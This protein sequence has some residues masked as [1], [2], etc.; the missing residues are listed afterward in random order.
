M[1]LIRFLAFPFSILYAIIT[2]FRNF[3]FDVGIFKSTTFQKPIIAVGNLSVGGTGKTPQIEYLINLLNNTYKIAVLSRGY[4]RKTNGFYVADSSSS[5][6]DIGDEPLQFFR[7]FEDVI[8]AVDENR[9]HGIQQLEQLENKP[10][11]ILLDDA[12]QHRKVK[13]GFYVM[14]TKYDDLFSND[15]VLPTGNLRE[16]R[17]GAKRADVIV[18]TKSPKNIDEI[19][20]NEIKKL[21]SRYFKGAI[22]FSTIKYSENLKSNTTIEIATSTL[23]IYNVLLVTGIAN[24]A[25]IT[26]YLTELNCSFSHLKYVDHHSFSNKE[27]KD[28]QRQFSELKSDTKIILT[29]EKDFVRLSHKIENLYYLPIENQFIN[30]KNEFDELI[31]SYVKK[32]L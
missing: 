3:L 29:T 11:V 21:I 19:E 32:A 8:V 22:F 9:V 15:F 2:S 30:T 14:L 18:V 23:K 7:K 31:K 5:S 27:I 4:G 16:R 17:N 1:K 26:T 25:P 20:Q 24:P 12:F 6:E 28:I 10:E 13:A